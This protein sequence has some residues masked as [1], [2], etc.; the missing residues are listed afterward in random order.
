MHL[1]KLL[2]QSSILCIVQLAIIGVTML[3]IS[4]RDAHRFVSNRLTVSLKAYRALV[5]NGD[6]F[7]LSGGQTPARSDILSSGCKALEHIAD[8]VL[9]P[10][11]TVY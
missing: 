8:V 9:G 1:V 5:S 11:L 6:I 10:A 4:I 7:Q 2:V 3:V